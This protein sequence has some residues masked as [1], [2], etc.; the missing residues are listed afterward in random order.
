MHNNIIVTDSGPIIHL[1]QI[2]TD[3]AWKIFSKINVPD[4]VHLEITK[5]SLPGSNIFKDRRFKINTSNKIILEKAKNL[6]KKYKMGKNDSII[7]A[8]AK[9]LKANLLLTDDLELRELASKAKIKPVGSVGIL[10]RSFI[11]GY[12]DIKQLFKHLDS[13]FTKSSLYITKDLIQ[14]VKNSALDYNKK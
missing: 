7:F 13:L 9:S 6:H 5:F 2:N 12:C 8:H 1:S 4:I 14:N 3:F 10:Y 11:E